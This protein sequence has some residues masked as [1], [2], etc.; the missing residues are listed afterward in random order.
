MSAWSRAEISVRSESAGQT[1]LPPQPLTIRRYRSTTGSAWLA[2][3]NG[4]YEPSKYAVDSVP[5]AV[6]RRRRMKAGTCPDWLKGVR[7]AA[8]SAGCFT[9]RSG[10]W[11]RSMIGHD[12][13]AFGPR[14][15]SR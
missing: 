10:A 5:A 6:H 9:D 15:T 13:S 1:I 7:D 3:P 12:V 11:N 2:S 14:T 8:G 4:E